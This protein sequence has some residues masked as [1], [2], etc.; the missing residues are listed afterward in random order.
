MEVAVAL[1]LR[2]VLAQMALWWCS[3]H[4][5]IQQR[6][7]ILPLDAETMVAAARKDNNGHCPTILFAPS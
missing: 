2:A 5:K 1:L 7:Q 6:L 4:V 3:L